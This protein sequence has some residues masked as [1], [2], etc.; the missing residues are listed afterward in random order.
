MHVIQYMDLE[1]PSLCLGFGFNYQDVI[2]T[3]HTFIYPF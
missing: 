1:I 3:R 2:L